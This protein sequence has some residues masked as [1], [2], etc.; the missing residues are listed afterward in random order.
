MRDPVPPALKRF[1]WDIQSMVGLAESQREI[2]VIGRDVMARLVASDDW[3]PALFAGVDPERGQQ[4]QL[5]GD[6][7]ERFSVVSTMLS[8]GQALPICQDPV[9]EIA[10]V[11]R[12]AVTRQRFACA[13]HRPPSRLPG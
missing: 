1:I 9:R 11:L 5:Y 12:G 3:L 10:G 8:G 6:Q 7:L 13:E 2:L 4:L